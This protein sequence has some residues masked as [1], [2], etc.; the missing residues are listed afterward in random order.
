MYSASEDFAVLLVINFNLLLALYV[1]YNTA[2]VANGLVS[3]G[4]LLLE[5]HFNSEGMK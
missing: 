4:V 2:T 1:Q 3:N 5:F